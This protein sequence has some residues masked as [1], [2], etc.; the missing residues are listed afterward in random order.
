MLRS[1]FLQTFYP[2]PQKRSINPQKHSIKRRFRNQ[3]TT[4]G[5]G[6]GLLLLLAGVTGWH[7]LNSVWDT[8]RA[9]LTM[10][11][12]ISH[13]TENRFKKAEDHFRAVI[14]ENPESDE[15]H[16]YLALACA[17]AQDYPCAEAHAQTAISLAPHTW[18]N[19]FALGN[20]YDNLA[21]QKREQKDYQEAQSLYKK[22]PS[23]I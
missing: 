3:W 20:I 17:E 8:S 6:I 13:L 15:A 11:E 16:Y 7:H 21:G 23:T 10:A 12:G 9:E 22:S 4:I 19:Y 18:Q 14:Q 2:S 1:S 5:A